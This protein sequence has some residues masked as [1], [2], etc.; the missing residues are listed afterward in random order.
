MTQK[1]TR[2]IC[3][4]AY[5]NSVEGMVGNEDVGQMS[6]WYV[7]AATGIH[8]SCPATTRYE[9]TSPVF[10]EVRIRLDSTYF[11][12]KEFVVRTRNNSKTNCYI[13]R[14]RLNGKE[15]N[16]CYI[17]FKDI[18]AGGTLELIMGDTPGFF[19]NS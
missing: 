13:Q 9:I 19:L 2:H 4:N 1:W 16:K 8:P 5:R 7:L 10:D 17:D 11:K 18:V 12:G 6:A 14:A 3:E 15:Y